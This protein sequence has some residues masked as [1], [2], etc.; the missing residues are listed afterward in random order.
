MIDK[1]LKLLKEKLAKVLK[2]SGPKTKLLLLLVSYVFAYAGSV[3]NGISGFLPAIPFFIYI[4]SSLKDESNSRYKLLSYVV[5]ALC[6]SLYILRYQQGVIFHPPIGK[7]M[8]TT[9]DK[10]LIQL[11]SSGSN[12]FISMISSL[13]KDG[14]CDGSSFTQ[15][16]KWQIFPRGTEVIAKKVFVSNAD[17]GE[18]YG[19]NF[20]TPFGEVSESFYDSKED[21]YLN[22]YNGKPIQASDL[23][24]EIFYLPSLLMAWPALPL[25]ALIELSDLFR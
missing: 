13:E 2:S 19:V 20:D 16:T 12:G 23:R 11:K 10:C 8:I 9:K 22:W 6:L 14:R 24:R 7:K 1:F 21:S 18:R 4:F 15:A 25:I 3:N 17:F 5:F